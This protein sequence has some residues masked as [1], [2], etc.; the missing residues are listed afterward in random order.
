[1]CPRHSSPHFLNMLGLVLK[2]RFSPVACCAADRQSRKC[3]FRVEPAPCRPSRPRNQRGT[4]CN[5][6]RQDRTSG[7]CVAPRTPFRLSRP[8]KVWDCIACWRPAPGWRLRARAQSV[9]VTAKGL[10]AVKGRCRPLD[11]QAGGTYFGPYFGD[12]RVEDV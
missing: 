10:A 11:F 2:P 8:S 12:A 3:R 9:R 5:S 1:M 4:C 6:F 7:L